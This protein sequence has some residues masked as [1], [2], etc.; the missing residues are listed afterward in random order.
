[1]QRNKQGFVDFNVS[2]MLTDRH[3]HKTW[4]FLSPS[5]AELK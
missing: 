4:R 5:T 1:M 2:I 3:K